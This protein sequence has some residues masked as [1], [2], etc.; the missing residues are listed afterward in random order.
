MTSIPQPATDYASI[1]TCRNKD[2]SA[3]I[4]V[5]SEAELFGKAPLRCEKGHA[6][7]YRRIEGRPS[8]KPC[9]ISCMGAKSNVCICS[10][11]GKNH[12]IKHG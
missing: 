11:R 7:L 6:Y 4:R 10:C 9:D 3:T 2:H 8:A 12:G 1:A 5:T